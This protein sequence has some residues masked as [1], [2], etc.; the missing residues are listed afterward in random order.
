[1]ADLR[2]FA[3]GSEN[4]SVAIVVAGH[5]A[6]RPPPITKDQQREPGEPVSVW[7]PS[8]W[9]PN[10]IGAATKR[11]CPRT[12]R[13]YASSPWPEV[14]VQFQG[15]RLGWMLDGVNLDLSGCA[16]PGLLS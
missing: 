15:L 6:C 4:L 13:V 7:R 3:V 9:M 1:M 5:R 10:P 8:K 11:G 12:G 2:F 14:G 16:Q